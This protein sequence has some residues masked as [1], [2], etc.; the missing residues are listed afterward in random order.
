MVVARF[1]VN[2]SLDTTSFNAPTGY[3]VVDLGS[4]SGEYANGVALLDDGR[5]VVAGESNCQFGVALLTA[6][7]VLDTS[8]N[9]TGWRRHNLPGTCEG[10]NDVVVQSTGRIVAMGWSAAGSA[11][12]AYAPDGTIDT[13][14]SAPDGIS[15]GDVPGEFWYRYNIDSSDRLLMATGQMCSCDPWIYR[16]TADGAPD[17]SF[18]GDGKM[19][20]PTSRFGGTPTL[21][22]ARSV[23][24]D[25]QGRIVFS[26][27]H[28]GFGWKT[29]SL[30]RLLSD[31]SIDNSL[32]GDG[33]VNV[34]GFSREVNVV[35]AVED[36]A[37]NYVVAFNDDGI[38]E[39]V[40]WARFLQNG[41]E[42]LTVN[43]TG[44]TI[45][46]WSEEYA[47][48]II[49]IADG[50]YLL[51]GTSGVATQDTAL[52]KYTGLPIADFNNDVG[53]AT[54]SDWGTPGAGLFGACL[55]GI[56]N[57]TTNGT[58]WTPDLVGAADCAEADAEPW[59]AIPATSASPG[60][61]V[62]ES[63]SSGESQAQARL[64]FGLR[65]K[66]SQPP[67]HYVAPITFEV[68]APMV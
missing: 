26:A 60:A 42:D 46:P 48:S 33:A 1:N 39:G 15:T 32:G 35:D 49:A 41:S 31:G 21:S 25:S 53:D 68:I 2:G 59:R 58:T 7:G 5:I 65:V 11:F 14:F 4:S 43:N 50:G 3:R 54:G 45:T 28:D 40:G 16:A 30:G 61:K 52:W 63:D 36:A 47:T 24:E 64:R 67:G 56:Q 23:F 20:F 51:A 38:W 34:D 55:I 17:T 66:P 12:A 27:M 62:L 37:G 8:F 18:S 13:T 44:F 57:A 9:G 22:W 6:S 29:V 10:A 19:S